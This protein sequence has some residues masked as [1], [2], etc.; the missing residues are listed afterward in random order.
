MVNVVDKIIY[1]FSWTAVEVVLSS[2]RGERNHFPFLAK[3]HPL[4][5]LTGPPREYYSR[6]YNKFTVQIRIQEKR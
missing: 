2:P 1:L 4:F 5:H 3:T 6:L